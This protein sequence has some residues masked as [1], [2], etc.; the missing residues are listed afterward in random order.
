MFPIHFG[1]MGNNTAAEIHAPLC[2]A[3]V[4]LEKGMRRRPNR[5]QRSLNAK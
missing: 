4:G 5:S 1:R 3:G 2:G